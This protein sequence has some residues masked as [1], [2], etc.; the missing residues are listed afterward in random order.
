[1]AGLVLRTGMR[2]RYSEFIGCLEA[3][4]RDLSN[5]ESPAILTRKPI[6]FEKVALVFTPTSRILSTVFP[7]SDLTAENNGHLI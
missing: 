2:C 1:M 4:I 3:Y 5:F 6:S 7:Q